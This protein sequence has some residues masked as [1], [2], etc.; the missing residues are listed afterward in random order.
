MKT[1]YIKTILTAIALMLSLSASAYSFC[2]D[3]IYYNILS[4]DDL[5][6]EVT[7]KCKDDDDFWTD[8]YGDI[9]I[10]EYVTYSGKSYKVTAIGEFAFCCNLYDDKYI[11]SISLPSTLTS[12]GRYAFDRAAFQGTSIDIPEGVTKIDEYA[13]NGCSSLTSISL[14]KSLTYIGKHA[15]SSCFNVTGTLT[16]PRNITTI[17][18]YTFSSWQKIEEII[19]PQ[20]VTYIENYAFSTCK[21][22]K[23]VTVDWA[24][25]KAPES[26]SFEN[27]DLSK[28]TL[29]VPYGTKSLYE[30][31]NHWKDFGTIEERDPI[32]TIDFADSNVKAICVDNWDSNGDGELS[33]AEAAVVTDI[34]TLFYNNTSIQ[35][36][37]ELRYFTGLSKIPNSA[38]KYCTNLT[39]VVLPTSVS[40]IGDEAFLRCT[41]LTSITL[42]N[43]VTSI[44]NYAFNSCSSLNS[45]EIPS[46]VLTIGKGAFINCT[47]ITSLEIPNSV[48]SLGDV[49]CSDCTGLESV[50]LSNSIK[51]IGS[52][53][54]DGCTNLN[55][56]LIPES[57]T[58]I[59]ASAFVNCTSLS[60]MAIP[61][62]VISI[63]NNAFDSCTGLS[64][65]SIGNSVTDI[66]EKAFYKC[67]NLTSISIPKSVKSIGNRAFSG[68]TLSTSVIFEPNSALTYIG[69]SAFR[70]CQFTSVTIP[71]SVITIDSWAFCRCD[72]LS[73]L[74]FEMG[75]ELQTI[76]Q[77]AF[78]GIPITT[79]TIPQHVTSIGESAFD[80]CSNL[81]TL[82]Y[83]EGTQNIL[84]A[85]VAGGTHPVQ[86]VVIPS[87]ATVICEN[88][89]Y[90]YF[91]LNSITLPQSL[92]S[93]EASAFKSCSGLTSV[94]LKS[95]PTFGA[96]VFYNVKA[97][98]TLELTDS[99]KPYIAD[100]TTNAPTISSGKYIRTLATGKW[101]SIVLPFV[102]DNVNDYKFYTLKEGNAESLTFT[103]VESGDVQAGVPY[104]YKNANDADI[105]TEMVKDGTVTM[106]VNTTDPTAV[107]NWQLKGA[108]RTISEV[109]TSYYVLSNNQF[110]NS[111]STVTI[112]PFRAYLVNSSSASAKMIIEIEGEG[113]ESTRIDASQIEGMETLGGEAYDLNGRRVT[114][115][116]KGIYIVN[117]KKVM[118]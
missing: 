55:S 31:T 85:H 86:H 45:L 106:T 84:W 22:V 51:S 91:N 82:I 60:S 80:D 59:G 74:S 98:I 17:Y 110:W 23:K 113:G 66:G 47:G 28:V 56:I 5:T 24:T 1:N 108:F 43:S 100:V 40:S 54:F 58:S 65:V 89:F 12:I 13:F 67:S 73:S 87:T 83:E 48:T 41:G 50:T 97:P 8:C 116:Q 34:G 109:N 111:T 101:G 16:I 88:A 115:P 42:S 18:S 77:Y 30:S 76:G 53:A 94:A 11:T 20:S 71:N 69:S 46:S 99:E 27:V 39:S 61:N 70:E 103:E 90:N 26:Y 15:F 96:S 107:G 14:P 2:V 63:G 38:F 112:N 36:F 62:S 49:I 29:S 64:T 33:E 25:P 7:Y 72:Y 105:K 6:V 92:Q 78:Y 81:T 52:R 114:N 32:V 10:P 44:G 104:L 75:S 19:I 95:I 35:T 93:I 102:P 57:V 3:G 68:C 79:L 4:S 21:N 118:F 117:G 9:T 37:D